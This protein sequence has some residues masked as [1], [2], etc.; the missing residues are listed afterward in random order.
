MTNTNQ[1]QD[2]VVARAFITSASSEKDNYFF[3][4]NVTEVEGYGYFF[5]PDDNGDESKIY[6]ARGMRLDGYSDVVRI[7]GNGE[8]ATIN[9]TYRSICNGT[10]WILKIS[11]CVAKEGLE[12]KHIPGDVYETLDQIAERI[13]YGVDNAYRVNATLNK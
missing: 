7:L 8:F 6:G 1:N 12:N 4:G 2:N 11:M 9:R 10:C 13:I 3:A 5:T